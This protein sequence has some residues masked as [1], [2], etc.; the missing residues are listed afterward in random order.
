LNTYSIGF[1]SPNESAPAT[2]TWDISQTDLKTVDF[3][4]VGYAGAYS[5]IGVSAVNDVFTTNV[6]LSTETYSYSTI[7]NRT[8]SGRVESSAA[9]YS[10]SEIIGET[11]NI[12]S[13]SA[14]GIQNYVPN[15]IVNARGAYY[16][17]V[18]VGSSTISIGTINYLNIP[19]GMSLASFS[20]RLQ[21]LKS[22]TDI[23][24]IRVYVSDGTTSI[25]LIP[26]TIINTLTLSGG[27]YNKIYPVTNPANPPLFANNAQI[28]VEVGVESLNTSSAISTFL[29]FNR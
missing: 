16:P 12:T 24:T 8:T 18:R 1:N 21:G 23:A 17:V 29:T 15:C 7:R 14:V 22:A 27:T 11:Y 3:R 5:I 2:P 25:D 9:V 13:S 4:S 28:Y 10:N 19:A 26:T 20:C 6:F